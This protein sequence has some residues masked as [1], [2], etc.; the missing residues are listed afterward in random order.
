MVSMPESFD[1]ELGPSEVDGETLVNESFELLL[2]EPPKSFLRELRLSTIS[3]HFPPQLG[4]LR[5]RRS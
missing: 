3:E 2:R 1:D 5:R 4:A